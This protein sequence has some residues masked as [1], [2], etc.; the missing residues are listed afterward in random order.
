VTVEVVTTRGDNLDQRQEQLETQAR[1]RGVERQRSAVA[2]A[3]AR[4]RGSDTIAGIEMLKRSLEP[5]ANAI[6]EYMVEAELKRGPR[7]A[8]FRLCG[9]CDPYLLAYL[10]GKVAIDRAAQD[11]PLLRTVMSIGAAVE[12]EFRLAA[13]EAREP[14][15]YTTIERSLRERSS[16]PDHSRLVWVASAAKANIELPRW[17]R[18]EKVQVGVVLFDLFADSTKI[19]ER[20]L[21]RRGRTRTQWR[22]VLSEGASEWFTKRNENAGLLRPAYL[23]TV[24]PPV[25]WTSL[26]G[27][28]YHTDVMFDI[29]LIKR[30]RPG[31][32]EDLKGADLSTVYAGVNA[33]QATGWRV[34]TQVLAVMQQ[35]WDSGMPLPCLP[36]RDDKA[37]PDKPFDIATNAEGRREW[38]HRAREVHTENVQSRGTRFELARLLTTATEMAHDEVIYFPHNLDF[39][40]RAYAVPAT[41]NPQGPDEAR[42][43][44]TFAQGKPL[45]GAGWWWL[46]VHGANLYGYD[47]VSLA[48]RARWGSDHLARAIATAQDPFA[49]LWWTEAD[50]PWSFLAWCFERARGD[51]ASSLPIALDGSCNGLQHFS[52]MLRDPIGG[53]ATN[54]MPSPTPA[55]I[56]QLVAD[57]VNEKLHERKAIP[58]F[59]ARFY[60]SGWLAFGGIDRKITKRPV[61]VLPYG[62]TRMSAIHYIRDEVR[63]RIRAGQENPFGDQL[64]RAEVWLSGLVW[65]AI[66]EVVVAARAA[67]DWLQLVV[68]VAA[69]ENTGTTWVA[70][71]GFIA[72][73]SYLDLK[74]RLVET[75]SRG[76]ILRLVD[77][78]ENQKIDR[79][80]Q[81]NGISPNFVHS[82]DAAVMMLT[83]KEA[84]AAGVTQFA[85]IHDSYGTTASDTDTLAH[86]LRRSFVRM[87][88]E[89]DV[90]VEFAAGV[91]ATLSEKTR[92]L[93]P[94]PPPKGNLDL[95]SVLTSDYFF[96]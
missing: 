58:D 42:G 61:M 28:G 44:L 78:T 35:A 80:R 32:I 3:L 18:N 34:N 70:P 33:I 96:A 68:R 21:K 40:G 37:I 31:H 92:L 62:G 65:T 57:R 55:D 72:H 54:L 14:R 38:R 36:M 91:S 15:L 51:D 59:E 10:A 88:E 95:Q 89:H 11:T 48:D 19:V 9:A 43:L 30:T 63:T 39:R 90:L 74:R 56:Y 8:V 85:M 77:Y 47:K 86:A 76:K 82:M 27:G 94:P 25:P 41:L 81:A 50:K 66:G 5:A 29:P 23:P 6:A 12:D 13:F 87:Y 71:S 17:S 60:A 69:V 49:D 75:K 7:P 64:P 79:V 93:L 16:S 4:G 67:M 84:L 2:R 26:R 1:D 83:I 53:A 20:K 45:T 73:Q 22:A 24:V 46:N 52:A